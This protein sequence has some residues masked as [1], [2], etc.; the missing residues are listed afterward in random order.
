MLPA[1]ESAFEASLDIS[2]DFSSLRL[3]AIEGV[4]KASVDFLS[5]QCFKLWNMIICDVPEVWVKKCS[6]P[7]VNLPFEIN[8]D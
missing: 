5:L 8:G 1:I 4:F 2:G 3:A 6:A 7:S